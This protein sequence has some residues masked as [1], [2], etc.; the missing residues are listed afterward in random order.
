MEITSHFKKGLR[1]AKCQNV[2]KTLFRLDQIRPT[3]VDF[4]GQTFFT[5]DKTFKKT[6]P[7]LYCSYS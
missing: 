3:G 6:L 7:V 5:Y 2:L 1:R 4:F